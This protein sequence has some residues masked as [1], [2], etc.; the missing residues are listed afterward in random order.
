M[1]WTDKSA[2][3]V[4]SHIRYVLVG[5]EQVLIVGLNM[6]DRSGWLPPV[7]WEWL[8]L[9]LRGAGKPLRE[10]MPPPPPPRLR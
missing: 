5:N 6:A 2:D 3:H 4:F 7:F 10:L 8:D 9:K 1:V